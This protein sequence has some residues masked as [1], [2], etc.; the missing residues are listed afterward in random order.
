MLVIW[1]GRAR[2]I[3]WLYGTELYVQFTIGKGGYLT[4]HNLT[5]FNGASFSKEFKI[6]I[7]SSSPKIKV[8]YT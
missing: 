4:G 5:T 6:I 3:W 1:K 8:E 2:L 7:Q